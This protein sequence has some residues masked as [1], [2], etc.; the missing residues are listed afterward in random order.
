MD[1]TGPAGWLLRVSAPRPLV[2]TAPGGTGSRL[3]VERVL[4]EHGLRRALS[5]AEA[6][7][8][9]ECGPAGSAVDAAAERVWDQIGAPRARVRV[10]SPDEAAERLDAARTAL[11]DLAAQRAAAQ[12]RTS[13][14][15]E[16]GGNGQGGADHCDG[17]D[18]ADGAG[19]EPDRGGA[20]HGEGGGGHGNGRAGHGHQ[21]DHHDHGGMDLPG[22]LVMADRGDDRDG[23]RLDRLHIAIGPAHADWPAGLVAELTVQ[24]DVVQDAAIRTPAPARQADPSAAV[25]WDDSSGTALAPA[26]TR[27]RAAASADSLQRF[28]ETAGLPGAAATG[29]LLRDTLLVPAAPAIGRPRFTRWLRRLRRSQTL[30]WSL[31]GLGPAPAGVPDRLRGD[32]LA[33]VGRWLDDIAAVL[34]PDTH[35]T[36]P[37]LPLPCGRPSSAQPG[38]AAAPALRLGR[39]R[40]ECARAAVDALPGMLL[41]RELAAV[42]LIVASLDPDTEALA[43]YLPEAADG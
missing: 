35:D 17:H 12:S 18:Q 40:A 2:V 21:H 41:G 30:R 16:G 38:G 4:R 34:I 15:G 32:V 23:L 6:D 33:R 3:A 20:G 22:G 10:R 37:T 9:V 36:F 8:L 7:T 19:Q 29:R 5:P 11:R 43:A 25:F 42:R 1:L 39:E 31:R 26:G 27:L 24:G 13:E 28:L 14:P